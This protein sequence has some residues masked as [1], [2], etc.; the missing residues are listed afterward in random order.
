VG[1]KV[2]DIVGYNKLVLRSVD[3]NF[4]QKCNINIWTIK[5]DFRN[6]NLMILLSYIISEHKDWKKAH[7]TIHTLFPTG[8]KAALAKKVRKLIRDGR[9]PISERSVRIHTY[10]N[11]REISDI[12][13]K[14]S[15]LCDLTMIGFTQEQVETQGTK[16]FNRYQDLTDV[17]FVQSSQDLVIS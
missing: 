5:E 2:A 8:E 3:N 17:L 6:I 11:E 15:R 9:L 4:G 12:I 13:K 14:Y 10:Q 16:V 7:I 1:L